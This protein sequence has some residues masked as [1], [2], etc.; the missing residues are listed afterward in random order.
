MKSCTAIITKAP[1]TTIGRNG[2]GRRLGL[3]C[4]RRCDS[5]F[6]SDASGAGCCLERVPNCVRPPGA[7]GFG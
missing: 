7:L 4:E 6:G 5:G 1:A 3:S 2:N